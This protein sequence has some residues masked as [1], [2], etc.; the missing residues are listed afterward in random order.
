MFLENKVMH[1]NL[2][3]ELLGIDTQ[4]NEPQQMAASLS[5]VE[6]F[7]SH[8][9]A[10]KDEDLQNRKCQQWV[11]SQ[12]QEFSKYLR[13]VAGLPNKYVYSPQLNVLIDL[14]RDLG[15]FKVYS[16][17]SGPGREILRSYE[18]VE[19][20]LNQEMYHQL[21]WSLNC[22]FQT[23]SFKAL[24]SARQRESRVRYQD[25]AKYINTLFEHNDRLIVIRIDLGYAVKQAVA[26]NLDRAS[27]DLDHLLANR[28]S[29]KLFDGMKGY[30]VKTELGVMKDIHFH[31]LLFFNGSERHGGSHVYL[32]KEIGEYWKNEITKGAGV[33]WNS[34]A[35]IQDFVQQGTC[36]IGLIHWSD[37]EMR[38]N[39][40]EKVLNYL[41][42]NDQ[43]FKPKGAERY[44]LLRRGQCA[45]MV[46]KKGRPRQLT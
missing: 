18:F 7:L 38:K 28:R 30:I 46:T 24:L 37:Q 41:L 29:N 25:Y 17:M 1:I 9:S 32:A 5:E 42:K 16:M 6:Q 33:Y 3:E 26:L 23:R 40:L 12:Y 2:I 45:P 39:L 15:V 11:S 36:G 8:L 4:N 44:K 13:L 20:S 34:N 43:F 19:N 14:C 35:H 31:A 27:S 22:R 10:L 21:V